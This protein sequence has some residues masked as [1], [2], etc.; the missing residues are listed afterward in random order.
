M[1]RTALGPAIASRLEDPAVVEVMLNPDGQLWID[2]L[3]GGLADTGETLLAAAG[4]RIVRLV[5]HYVGAEAHPGNPRVSAELPETGDRF[6]GSASAR[7]R[8]RHLCHPQAGGRCLHARRLRRR[9]HQDPSRRAAAR[10]GAAQEHPGFRWHLDRQDDADQRA[11]GGSREVPASRP[12]GAAGRPGRQST[13]RGA[14][15]ADV[16][17]DRLLAAQGRA[18]ALE[19]ARQAAAREQAR[20]Q[21]SRLQEQTYVGVELFT[22]QRTLEYRL[23]RSGRVLTAY[24]TRPLRVARTPL[25]SSVS[26]AKV[27]L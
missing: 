17:S 5:A 21:F 26:S 11:A 13:A 24:N 3:R 12:S 10:G 9:R 19:K 1:L 27:A 23:F 14:G 20:E 7:C 8:R 15:K 25:S 18:E 16:G 6:E 22:F 4:E 2:R